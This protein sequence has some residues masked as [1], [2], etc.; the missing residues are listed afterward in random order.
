MLLSIINNKDFQP[1]KLS[2]LRSTISAGAPIF[3]AQ[4]TMLSEL[5][6]NNHFTSSYGLSEMAPISISDYNDTIV[7]LCYFVIDFNEKKV[8]FHLVTLKQPT[9]GIT[10]T[11]IWVSTILVIIYS[12]PRIQEYA[13]LWNDYL[14]H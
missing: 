3:E 12:Y 6:S 2:T 8:H 5:L 9:K 11:A 7:A 4:M 1:E 14:V 13:T 10:Y